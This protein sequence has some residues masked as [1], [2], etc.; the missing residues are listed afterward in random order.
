MYLTCC[1][2]QWPEVR[3]YASFPTLPP[4]YS[5][6]HK[7]EGLGGAQQNLLFDSMNASYSS[8]GIEKE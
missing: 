7:A 4:P 3:S 5:I 8:Q 2:C 6:Q 1:D